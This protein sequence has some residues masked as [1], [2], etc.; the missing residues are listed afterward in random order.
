MIFMKLF[1]HIVNKNISNLRHYRKDNPFVKTW[2]VIAKDAPEFLGINKKKPVYP[3]HV[4]IVIIGGGF[5]GSAT[6]YWLKRR[7]ADGLSIVVLEKDITYKNIQNNISLGTLT[8]H[9]SLPENVFLSQYGT[10]FIRKA[11][12]NL[13]DD[14]DVQYNPSGYL[15]L[16][17][18]KYADKLETTVT[19]QKEYGLKN[20]LLTPDEINSRYPWINTKDVQLGCIGL[21]S[22]GVVNSW[23]LLKGLVQKAQ[24]L[25]TIYVNA[26]VVGFEME[27]QRDVLMEGVSPGTYEKINKVVYR[28]PDN[29]EYAI[30]FAACILAAGHESGEIAKLAKVGQ[31][32]GLLSIPLPI[33][34]RQ[35]EIYSIEN[36]AKK[37]GLNTPIV[38][39]TSGLW[40]RRNCLEDN[41]LCGLVPLIRDDSKT[42][43]KEDY[44]KNIIEPTLINRFPNTTGAQVLKISSELQD[45]NTYDDTGI[46]GPH[47]YHNNLYIAAGFGKYGLHHAPGIGRA[48]SELIIDSHYSTID[49]TRLG[50]D[51]LLI[52]E[53][54]VE[55]NIY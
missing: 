6:A 26:E 11:K 33:E 7:A 53:P 24:Q 22:E 15:V 47:P 30:K 34:S 18:E 19:I 2:K 41:L 21:E 29:E 9:F 13:G 36:E 39:D 37:T 10:E 45:C 8:Q 4:D 14:V 46:L 35:Y 1:S 38:M 32:E 55:F 50:F 5:I 25:G 20:E 51:R 42:L 40:L 28:T 23:A 44:Y 12:E 3:E 16:A 31:S 52:N 48:I 43:S 49:L 54:L 17:S 27:K